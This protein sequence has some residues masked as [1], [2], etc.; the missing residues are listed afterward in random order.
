MDDRLETF[1]DTMKV[2]MSDEIDV[3]N[4]KIETLAQA[5]SARTVPMND[6][7]ILLLLVFLTIQPLLVI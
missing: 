6:I 7:A 5:P 4:K 3:I 1:K 2:E